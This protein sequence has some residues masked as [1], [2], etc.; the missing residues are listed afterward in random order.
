M[1]KVEY[2]KRIVKASKEKQIV[3]YRKPIRLSENFSTET[4]SVI[5]EFHDI[6]KEL[7]T[8]T[9]KEHLTKNTL[10]GKANTQ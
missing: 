10:T 5:R 8:T 4:L 7:K 6:F 2:K 3:T 9:T 1:L